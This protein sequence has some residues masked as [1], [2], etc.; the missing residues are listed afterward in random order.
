MQAP[1]V[2]LVSGT[3]LLGSTVAAVFRRAG[4]AI[5]ATARVGELPVD[6]ERVLAPQ[7]DSVM[8]CERFTHAVLCAAVADPES[9]FR[10]PDR[11]RRVNQDAVA[12]LVDLC[13]TWNVRP[14]F[15]STDLVFS[16][17]EDLCA[18]TDPVAPGTAYGRQKA[19]AERSVLRGGEGAAVIR[20][21]KLMSQTLHPR[22]SLT[23]II[24]ACA[25]GE[26]YR[27]FRDQ[28]VAPVFAEDAARAL[29]TV[30]QRGMRGVYHVAG[31]QCFSRADLARAVCR[32]LGLGESGIREIRLEEFGFSEPRGRFNT[33]SA[34]KFKAETGFRF[35][36]LEEG[37][38]NLRRSKEFR[39]MVGP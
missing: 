21:G 10:D 24:R 7:L 25:G 9:C 29:L 18:E 1:K 36:S 33:L 37:L 19:A 6:L 32:G 13:R 11:S 38:Q 20:V 39:D 16:G 28:Y 17:N 12:E 2:L 4:V 34:A 3:G 30:V 31:D 8:E 26:E 27:A 35:T 15:V 14:V 22:S 23:P 5:R